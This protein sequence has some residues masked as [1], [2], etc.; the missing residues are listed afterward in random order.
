MQIDNASWKAGFPRLCAATV[1]SLLLCCP[2]RVSA[3]DPPARVPEYMIVVTGDELLAGEFSDGHTAFIA[4]TLLPLG[5]RCVRS[6]IVNDRR[7]D[8]QES[9]RLATARVPLVIVTGGLG[10][11]K[12]DVT[13]QALADFTGIPLREQPQVLAEIAA[14]FKLRPDQ[15][16]SNL[17]RQTLVPTRGA[18]L[19]S[20]G[21]TAVGL[22]FEMPTAV[23]VA[24]PGPPR[25]L[26]PMVRD[27]LVPYL[28]RRYGTRSPAL[29]LRLR[30]VG[31]GQSQISH[32]LDEHL[33]LS[34]QIIV[35]STFEGLR[36]DFTFSLPHDTPAGR[37]ML[38]QL[39][40]QILQE[41]GEYVYADDATT[42]EEL[43]VR[44]LREQRVTLALAEAGSGGVLAAALTGTEDAASVLAGARVAPSEDRLRRMLRV[45][46]DAWTSATTSAQRLGLIAAAAD[47]GAS[48]VVVVG[49]V[50]P[51][52]TGPR[53][54]MAFRQPDGRLSVETLTLRG[55]GELAR[56][57]LVTQLLDQLRRRLK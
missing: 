30:F 13:R 56:A 52:A 47:L 20:G 54:E 35:G 25:E 17:R 22:V 42:L 5:F 49:E 24:L 21:G 34:P 7:D 14:R 16:R 53:V 40:Q 26:Q 2:Q 8:I 29:S 55:T 51:Q 44:R 10:P 18:Y 43:V 45:T 3:A 11:T 28:T 27:E 41:L 39:K 36:V 50:R 6:M 33:H 57:N 4:R 48:W 46:D 32:T 38:A 1:V 19:K 12:N 15:L 37:A 23:V 31:L 9:L